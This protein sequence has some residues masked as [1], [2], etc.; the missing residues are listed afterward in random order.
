MDN[1]KTS[2]II[3]VLISLFSCS[4]GEQQKPADLPYDLTAPQKFIMSSEL[5]EIS[6]VAI[7]QSSDSIYAIQD[8]E[9]ILFSLLPGSDKVTSRKFG[10]RGDYEDLTI[11]GNTAYILKS[12]GTIYTV[13][14]NKS[15]SKESDQV[16]ELKDLLPQ[17]EYEGMYADESNNKLYV[18]CKHCKKIPQGSGYSLAIAADGTLTA[19]ET[20]NLNVDAIQEITKNKKVNFHPSA[21]TKNK[22]TNEWFVLSSVNRILI[23][24]SAGWTIK[25]VY[26]LDPS[27]FVQPE[28]LAFDNKNNLYISNEA[29][30]SSNGNILKFN[31]RPAK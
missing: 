10:K 5:A 20:F 28:G 2:V 1:M 30:S 7:K 24:A 25:N 9:G 3:P 29:G 12:N 18:L 6:G 4:G 23:R 21:I 16:Q 11:A 17:G 13:P 19:S 14:L 8:E 22:V 27:I 31:Y 26:P 15:I